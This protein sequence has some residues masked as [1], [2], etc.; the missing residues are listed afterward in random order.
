MVESAPEPKKSKAANPRKSAASRR[1]RASKGEAQTDEELSVPE[2]PTEAIEK[3]IVEN[4]GADESKAPRRRKRKGES[5][6]IDVEEAKQSRKSSVTEVLI[7][8][9]SRG[10]GKGKNGE[11]TDSSKE[12]KN[13]EEPSVKRGRR[14]VATIAEKVN[15]IEKAKEEPKGK[16]RRGG[17]KLEGVASLSVMMTESADEGDV[18]RA[19]QTGTIYT[20]APGSAQ[21]QVKTTARTRGRVKKGEKS[22]EVQG[23]ETPKNHSCSVKLLKIEVSEEKS[24]SVGAGQSGRVSRKPGGKKS[25]LADFTPISGVKMDAT[26]SC[27]DEG[28]L[29]VLNKGAKAKRGGKEVRGSEETCLAK[30][31]EVEQPTKRNSRN[32]KVSRTDPVEEK[33]PDTQPMEEEVEDTP[34]TS[35][36]ASR[37]RGC[38]NARPKIGENHP[39]DQQVENLSPVLTNVSASTKI[40]HEGSSASST[41]VRSRKR[42][43]KVEADERAKSTSSKR[44]L[45]QTST[46]SSTRSRRSNVTA[47]PSLRASPS[48]RPAVMFTGFINDSDSALVEGLGGF[49][50]EELSECTVLV[51][52]SM[53][54]TVKLLCMV[55]RGAPAFVFHSLIN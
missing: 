3:P 4:N 11:A 39:P 33:A 6:E 29:Q 25:S 30:K 8:T 24:A 21:V 16:L 23:D 18:K 7:S 31:T 37:K 52:D 46:A 55:G 48:S 27:D 42:E 41:S 32:S 19:D 1:G 9:S 40:K 14:A 44:Q 47:S 36:S 20:P 12:K 26:T 45:S 10:R 5:E 22:E 50:T 53:K 15:S 43:I 13:E 54:R 49:L 17:R 34:A 2:V 35:K 51:A 28:N 38:S